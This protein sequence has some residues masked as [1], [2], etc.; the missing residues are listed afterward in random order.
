[1]YTSTPFQPESKASNAP[2]AA[3]TSGFF[4]A[5]IVLTKVGRTALM[6][7]S[8]KRSGPAGAWPAWTPTAA[9]STIAMRLRIFI[10]RSC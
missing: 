4:R 10:I 2:L 1:M 9:K 7:V 8:S 6:L 3:A 5:A